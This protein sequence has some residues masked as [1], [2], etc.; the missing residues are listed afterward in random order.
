MTQPT[1][2]IYCGD[3]LAIMSEMESEST[4]LI[5]LD[6]PFFSGK[7]Y[8]V[9]WKDGTEER[10]FKDTEWYRVECPKCEREVVKAER[11][12]PVCGTDLKDAKITRKNDIYAYIDWMVPRLQEMHRILK[13]TG[14]IYLH[15][16]HHAV[17]YLKIEMDRIFGEGDVSKG[18]KCFQNEIVWHYSNKIGKPST[19]CKRAHDNILFYTKSNDYT[20][21]P[22]LVEIDNE[23]TLKRYDHEDE[24]GIYKIYHTGGIDRKVYLKPKVSDDV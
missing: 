14:S 21:N 19:S 20:Y 17:H 8:E 6:P 23:L 22:I 2:T 13:P 9:I 10:S 11:F 12:C 7:N 3:N 24:N 15:V 16:D 5:Y 4:D 18:I 1:N